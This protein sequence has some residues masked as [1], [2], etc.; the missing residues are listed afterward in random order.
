MEFTNAI[1][2]QEQEHKQE[3]EQENEQ[4][5][6]SNELEYD[7]GSDSDSSCSETSSELGCKLY[8]GCKKFHSYHLYIYAPN[9]SKY[10]DIDLYRRIIADE[11]LKRENILVGKNTYDEKELHE[12]CIINE[13]L[14]PMQIGRAF[15]YNNKQD[16]IHCTSCNLII[17]Y[18][19]DF[20]CKKSIDEFNELFYPSNYKY[21][22]TLPRDEQ[23]AFI[24]QEKENQRN[25]DKTANVLCKICYKKNKQLIDNDSSFNVVNNQSGIGNCSNWVFVFM[26]TTYSNATMEFCGTDY[27]NFYCNLNP[28]SE[29]YGRFAIMYDFD[30]LGDIFKMLEQRTISEILAKYYRFTDKE[31][32][33]TYSELF[34]LDKKPNNK[35]DE[36]EVKDE[37]NT[38]I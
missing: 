10:Y 7:C 20:Y 27:T 16:A 12:N 19:M 6:I 11:Q 34:G 4:E 35:S 31:K 1:T 32:C 21:R 38:N 23:E 14:C 22:Y 17:P 15:K 2:E 36:Y 28:N 26:I 5:L 37:V 3:Q 9:T 24:K 25:F 13:I 8:N 33:V 29:Y 18:D 30:S